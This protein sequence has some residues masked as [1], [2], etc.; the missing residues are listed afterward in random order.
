MP[1]LLIILFIKHGVME[2]CNRFCRCVHRSSTKTGEVY[3][4]GSENCIESKAIISY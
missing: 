2:K 1:G 4:I 3:L